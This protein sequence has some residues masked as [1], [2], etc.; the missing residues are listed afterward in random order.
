[1]SKELIKK[2]LKEEFH[3]E[4]NLNE[5]VKISKFLKY[6]LDNKIP[7]SENIFRP[8]SESFFDLINEVKNLYKN[9]LIDL[10]ESDVELI[11][12]D[13]GK[14]VVLESGKVVYLDC[15]FIENSPEQTIVEAEYKGRKVDL[16]KPMRNTGG[17]KKYF[18]YVKNPSTKKIKKISFGDVKGGLTAKVSNPEARKNF[19]S[20]HNCKDKKDKTKAG[21]WA[22][23][24]NRYPHLWNNKSYPGF[25]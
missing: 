17:G 1:M 23:R 22:C 13:L 11:N 21:Y 25:W 15:P 12:T 4:M 14:Q 18:V 3:P 9:G 8:Y 16:N 6:H 5:N 7:L 2:I 10:T 20:R 19:A 24:I